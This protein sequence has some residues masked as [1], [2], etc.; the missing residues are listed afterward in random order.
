MANYTAAD[1]KKLREETDAPMM[2]CKTAL[3]EADGDFEKAK[4]I[5]REKGKAAAAKRADRA[6]S[7]GVVAV[8]AAD[9]GVTLGAVVV[10]SETDFVAK[11]EDFIAMCASMAEKVRDGAGDEATL[12][13]MAEEAVAKIRENIQVTKSIRFTGP[14]RVAYYVH[15]DRKSG[16]VIT[17]TGDV[18]A[19]A[20]RQVAIHAT[21]MRPQ[22]V[23]KDELSQEMLDKEYDIQLTRALNEGKP[24][25][26]AE[27][28]AKGR[29]NKEFIREA[30]LL[31]QPYYA[32]N[33]KTVGQYLSE[34]A[35]GATVTGMT[36]LAVGQK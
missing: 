26:I 28:I 7:E 5:L 17:F 2:E 20:V 12:K 16:A 9:D 15:H 35:K 19:E 30:V 33:S 21:A 4:Q 3:D 24:Q 31:E 11:N 25:N 1:V 34:S 14:D 6:T 36:L 8:S 23:G 13:A 22:V 32:D 27:N 10:E 18:D 29:V